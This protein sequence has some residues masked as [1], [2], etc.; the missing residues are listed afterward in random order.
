[1]KKGIFGKVVIACLLAGLVVGG[2]FYDKQQKEEKAAQEEARVAKEKHDTPH[3]EWVVGS[4]DKS[5]D[6]E[7]FLPPTT[8]TYSDSIKKDL[9]AKKVWVKM[10]LAKEESRVKYVQTSFLIL[11]NENSY[12][13]EQSVF[14]SS[15]DKILYRLPLDGGFESP[16]PQSNMD[17]VVKATCAY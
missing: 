10:I 5:A 2:W 14:Y 17:Y 7:A 6:F 4:V 12:K 11:C 16:V 1:M 3:W 9:P 8:T 13:K 15:D